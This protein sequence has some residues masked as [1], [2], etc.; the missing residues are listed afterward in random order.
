VQTKHPLVENRI[1]YLVANTVLQ[2]SGERECWVERTCGNPEMTF[3]IK[4]RIN[5]ELFNERTAAL[6]IRK[7]L[8]REVTNKVLALA[9]WKKERTSCRNVRLKDSTCQPYLEMSL[10]GM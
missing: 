3:P 5:T 7:T 4:K 8:I 6:Y 1:F 9:D 10:T 2:W